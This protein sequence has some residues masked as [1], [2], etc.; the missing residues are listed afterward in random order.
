VGSAWDKEVTTFPKK[1]PTALH[2]GCKLLVA[3][4][5]RESFFFLPRKLEK[6]EERGEEKKMAARRAVFLWSKDKNRSPDAKSSDRTHQLR[7]KGKEGGE[8]G[9]VETSH[10]FPFFLPDG[11]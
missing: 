9:K 11:R 5:M 7:L 6:M 1:G 8:K 4:K 3:G 10:L 2:A